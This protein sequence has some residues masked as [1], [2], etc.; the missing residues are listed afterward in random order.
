MK[1]K[2]LNCSHL[3]TCRKHISSPFTSS[4]AL[5]CYVLIHLAISSVALQQFFQRR[6]L[7]SLA[8]AAL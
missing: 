1:R 5:I 8:V 4:K 6:D 3:N 7:I 2:K